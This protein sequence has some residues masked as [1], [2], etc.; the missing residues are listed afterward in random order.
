MDYDIINLST[1]QCH[2]AS[3]KSRLEELDYYGTGVECEVYADKI[4]F[5]VRTCAHLDDD[6]KYES[7][8]FWTDD[9]SYNT[10]DTERE[11]LEQVDEYITNLPT[12]QDVTKQ[13]L[14]CTI[15]AARK[16]A[17]ELDIDEVFMNPLID[18]MKALAS[19]AITDRK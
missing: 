17:D 7:F 19:N 12:G 2:L 8:T 18:M 13:R 15:E 14:T 3:F 6:Y 1:V 16:M 11:L 5:S 4:R 9:G 10:V